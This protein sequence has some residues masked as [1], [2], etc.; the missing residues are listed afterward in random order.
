MI[1]AIVKVV[2]AETDWF[3]ELYE[4]AAVPPIGSHLD[5][6]D[7]NSNMWSLR[8]VDVRFEVTSLKFKEEWP[9]LSADNGK[10][11][12]LGERSFDKSESSWQ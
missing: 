3:P 7:C 5:I 8:V 10:I 6:M 12:I 9:S 2:G 4:I 11:L 1:E